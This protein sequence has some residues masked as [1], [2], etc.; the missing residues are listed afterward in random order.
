MSDNSALP[1]PTP[2]IRRRLSAMLYEAFLLLAVQFLAIAVFLMVTRDSHSAAYNV[3]LRCVMFVVAGAYF[4]Y[5]WNDSG[6]TLAMKTWRVKL[7]L[8]GHSA[9]PLR[10]AA[11]RFLLA[12]VWFLPGLL[13]CYGL[14]LPAKRDVVGIAVVM[15]ANIILWAL[16]ALLDQER[17]FLHDKMLGT[18]LIQLP[19]PGKNTSALPNISA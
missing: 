11:L 3:A 16:T 7:V 2:T 6:Q 19:K 14:R 1:Q 18:K 4:M 8:P 13:V 9:L 12:W 17:Q 5:F 15:L 10:L